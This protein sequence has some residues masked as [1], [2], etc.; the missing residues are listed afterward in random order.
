MQ[1]IITWIVI[2][3]ALT[4]LVLNIVRVSRLFKKRDP[5][6]GCGSVCDNCPVYMNKTNKGK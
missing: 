4:F 6:K 2:L 5:C 3:A 1:E